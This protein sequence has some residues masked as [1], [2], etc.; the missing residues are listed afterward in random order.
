M[1]QNRQ[2]EPVS[3]SAFATALGIAAAF[4]LATVFAGATVIAA[5]AATLPFAAI[6]ALAI[7]L[8]SL[9]CRRTGTGHAIVCRRTGATG[10]SHAASQNSGHRRRHEYCSLSSIH[11]FPFLMFLISKNRRFYAACRQ[12]STIRDSFPRFIPENFHKNNTREIRCPLYSVL[13]SPDLH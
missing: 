4:A 5:F 7:V 12:S 10:G 8:A 11:S 1:I 13:Q 2:N 6:F 3:A 9:V